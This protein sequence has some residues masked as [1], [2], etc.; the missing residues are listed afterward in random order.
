LIALLSG[1]LFIL[2]I[3]S[4]ETVLIDISVAHKRDAK[5]QE[6]SSLESEEGKEISLTYYSLSSLLTF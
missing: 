4:K 3:I 5:T 2:G 1:T 6:V